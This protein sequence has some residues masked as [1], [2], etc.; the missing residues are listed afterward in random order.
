[1]RRM[2][3]RPSKNKLTIDQ[4]KIACR[5]VRELIEAGVTE[6]LAIRSLEEFTD[7]TPK[8]TSPDR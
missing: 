2:A 3:T 4:L 8:C 6:N 1:M 5:H 7:F